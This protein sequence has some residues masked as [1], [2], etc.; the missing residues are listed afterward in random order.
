MKDI[1]VSAEERRSAGKIEDKFIGTWKIVSFEA[2]RSDGQTIYPYGRDAIGIINYDARG[3]MSVQLMRPDCPAFA[4]SDP[5]KGSPTETK[6]AFDGFIAYFGTYEI[7]EEKGTV[8]HR[9]RGCSFPNWVG[10][11]QIR[12][13]EFSGNRLTLRS[14]PMQVGGDTLALLFVWQQVA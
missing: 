4:I 12:F 1:S 2:R 14:P 10:S 3:N 11:D 6:T 13:F 9:L 7:N 5:Q 8:T